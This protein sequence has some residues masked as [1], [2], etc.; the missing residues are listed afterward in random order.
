MSSPPSTISHSKS[1][2]LTPA[3]SSTYF[4]SVVA[5]GVKTPGDCFILTDISGDR[6]WHVT[7]AGIEDI[8]ACYSALFV[9]LLSLILFV[10]AIEIFFCLFVVQITCLVLI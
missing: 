8:Y 6:V 3:G 2:T 4:R 10:S 5:G 9:F 7:L 1:G